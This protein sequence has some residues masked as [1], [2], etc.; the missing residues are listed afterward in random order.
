MRAPTAA[1]LPLMRYRC[2]AEPWTPFLSGL[3]MTI[4]KAIILSAGQ[5]SRLLPLTADMPKCMIDFN[6]RRP[7]ESAIFPSSPA[8][9][10]REWRRIW[11]G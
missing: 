8:F 9:A 7:M 5:G 3:R 1:F 10:R 11:L 2:A 4:S 6:G